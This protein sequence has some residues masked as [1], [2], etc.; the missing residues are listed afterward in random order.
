[1]VPSTGK[2]YHHRIR[3]PGLSGHTEMT[4]VVD[5]IYKKHGIYLNNT[6]I[7]QK[8]IEGIF[9]LKYAFWIDLVNRLLKS[10]SSDKKQ[11]KMPEKNVENVDYNKTDLNKLSDEELKEHKKRMDEMYY[12]NYRDPKSKDF[13]YEIE[14]FLTNL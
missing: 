10:Q 6:K 4:E 14:V 8:H 11:E 12:K 5:G 3:L 1:M 7:N 13:V 2:L 9:I